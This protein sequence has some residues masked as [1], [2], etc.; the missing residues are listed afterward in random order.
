MTSKMTTHNYQ[1]KTK[2]KTKQTIRTGAESQK[3]TSHGR[4]SAGR[5][6]GKNGEKVQ[7]V[8]NINGRYK[9][10]GD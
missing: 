6:R 10:G 9:I 7:R 2:T 5:G 3:W 8:R 1:Q 4:L